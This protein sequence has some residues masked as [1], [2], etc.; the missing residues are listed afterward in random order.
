MTTDT[1]N[2]GTA[3]AAQRAAG[4]LG[5]ARVGLWLLPVYA[6]LLALSTLTHQ[7]DARSDFPAYAR[8]VTTDLFLASHLVGSIVGGALGLL[9]VVA[10]LA[11]LVRGLAARLAVWG[12]ALTVVGNVIVTAV[13]GAAAFAQPA[14]GRAY[15]DGL[16]QVEAV[17]EDVY[18]APL[19]ATAGV[20]LLLL[21]AGAVTFG[22]A[23]RRTHRRLRWVGLGYAVCLAVFAMAGFLL[24]IVQPVAA[25]ALVVVT[26]VLARRLPASV[27]QG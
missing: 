3:L 11:F 13:F 19:F 7:P 15:L 5:A 26:V 22:L 25:A 14:I 6:A 20:G 23:I 8:Y 9:G 21:V 17:D 18:G 24:E 10:A 27:D 1:T 2:D 12:A 16:P 4:T